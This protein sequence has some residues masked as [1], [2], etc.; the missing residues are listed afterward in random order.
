MTILVF[1][2]ILCPFSFSYASI[3]FASAVLSGL[4]L[5]FFKSCRAFP[6]AIASLSCSFLLQG[7]FLP[8]RFIPSL[9]FFSTGII[10]TVRIHP[11]LALF[12]RRDDFDRSDSSPACSV[13]IYLPP[14]FIQH[15]FYC[16]F[17][18]FICIFSQCQCQRKL[19][20]SISYGQF[21][22]IVSPHLYG[23]LHL[24]ILHA[25]GHNIFPLRDSFCRITSDIRCV[26]HGILCQCRI[27]AFQQISSHQFFHPNLF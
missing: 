19:V 12:F 5:G 22:W 20:N 25:I 1:P 9:L 18:P 14:Q 7:L 24:R 3:V 27:P 21:S 15:F 4:F 17:N 13:T 11:Q 10:S 8:A 26:Q 23:H 6:R 16:F 2:V